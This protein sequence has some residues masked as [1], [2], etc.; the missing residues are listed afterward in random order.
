MGKKEKPPKEDKKTKSPEKKAPG[1]KKK[2]PFIVFCSTERAKVKS[3]L[4][5]ATF[6]EVAKEMGKRWK[7]LSDDEKAEFKMVRVASVCKQNVP[8]RSNTFENVK[9]KNLLLDAYLL[10]AL[11]LLCCFVSQ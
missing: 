3:D 7:A 9:L 5:D 8:T 4:P 10:L 2:S 6:G 11:C 1:T